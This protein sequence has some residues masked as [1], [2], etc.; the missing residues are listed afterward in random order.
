MDAIDE[1]FFSNL[2]NNS[3]VTAEKLRR[4]KIAHI[5][6][7]P[8]LIEEWKPKWVAAHEHWKAIAQLDHEDPRNRIPPYLIHTISP[9]EQKIINQ[10]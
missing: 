3:S 5:K 2:K 7:R 6:R 4:E 8:A 10:N 9:E 1:I